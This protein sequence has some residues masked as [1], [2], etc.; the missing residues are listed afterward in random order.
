MWTRVVSRMRGEVP[1]DTLEAYRRASLGVLELLQQGDTLRAKGQVEGQTAWTLPPNVQAFMLCSWN[2][3]VL[4]SLGNEFLDAD[5]RDNPATAGFVPPITADQ[6]M[7]FYS[8]V[9]GWL[10]RA[11]QAQ[12]NPDYRLDV[13]VPASLPQWSQVEPCPKSHLH[14]MLTAMTSIRDHV[15][16][17][18]T[19]LGVNPP[20]EPEQ[21]AQFNKIKQLHAAATAKARYA[22]DLHGG[23]PTPE[24]HERVE[25]H[26]K[27]S[28]EAFYK[29]GQ[30]IAMPSL[31]TD[32]PPPTPFGSTG[33]S[34]APGKR[35]LAL[36]GEPGFDPWC[37]TDP[38]ARSKWRADPDARRA[39]DTLWELNPDP[40]KTIRIQEEINEALQR[41]DIRRAHDR[42]GAPLGHF[43]CCPWAPIFEAV[44]PVTIGG[45]NLTPIEQFVFDV[46]AEGFHLGNPFTCQ[47]MVANFQPTSKTEY[48]DPNEEP[49]H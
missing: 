45:R 14:G 32:R 6:V 28:I 35:R 44:R 30:L 9:E 4:Q 8:Q 16:G 31:A 22:E 37:L 25:P 43:F 18:M 12:S 15:S 1:A 3:F 10:N 5:Y 33:V 40:E 26:I 19:F 39:I 21:L 13:R 23:D 7:S 48:G 41:G 34:R 11:L 2:A 47:I 36:P 38:K 24:M 27:E 49:D 17:A 46:N 42:N 29:L 20:T